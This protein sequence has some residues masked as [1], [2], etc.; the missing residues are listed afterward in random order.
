MPGTDTP[1]EVTEYTINHL[2]PEQIVDTNGAGDSFVGGFLAAYQL[3]KEFDDC[4]KVGID[5]ASQVV[6]RIGCSFPE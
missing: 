1:P 5:L 2:K 4:V 6:Q 3:G